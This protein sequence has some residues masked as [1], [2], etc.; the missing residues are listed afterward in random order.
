MSF[1]KDNLDKLKSFKKDSLK[2][3]FTDQIQHTSKTNQSKSSN[4]DNPEELFY[5]IIDNTSTLE[6]TTFLNEKLKNAENN[7][8]NSNI[9]KY[10][11]N[12]F[13]NPANF[14]NELS[15]EELLYDEFNYLL[16]E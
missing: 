5:S 14:N 2:N 12:K 8:F 10:N 4:N 9:D 16:E 6:E 3:K 7:L 15:E 11:S 1:S 13:S